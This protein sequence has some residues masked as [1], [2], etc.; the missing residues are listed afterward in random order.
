MKELLVLPQLCRTCILEKTAMWQMWYLKYDNNFGRVL[1]IYER[2]FQYESRLTLNTKMDTKYK[3]PIHK[4]LLHILNI[5]IQG[6]N[7]HH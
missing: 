2:D 3:I 6:F 7:T 4:V 5:K 1:K